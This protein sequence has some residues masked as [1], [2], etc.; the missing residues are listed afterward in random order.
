MRCGDVALREWLWV[1][2]RRDGTCDRRKKK[3]WRRRRDGD[4]V[5]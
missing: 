3:N 5:K 2:V 1:R 4:K